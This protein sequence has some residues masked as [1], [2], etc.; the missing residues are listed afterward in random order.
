MDGTDIHKQRDSMTMP[1]SP[2]LEP[3]ARQPTS[4]EP[5]DQLSAG[6]LR[7]PPLLRIAS[8]IAGML[9]LSCAAPVTAQ[10]AAGKQTGNS[11]GK[12]R[13]ASPPVPV[14]GSIHVASPLVVVS[15]TAADP[16][17]DFVYDLNQNEVQVLDNGVP[18]EIRHFGMA[19]QPTAAVIVVEADGRTARYMNTIHPLGPLF[20]DLLLGS[21]GQAAVLTYGDQVKLLESFSSD[22]SKLEKSLEQI[23]G[24]G[25]KA[26]L[27]DALA[28]AVRMLSHEDRADRR[29]VIVFSDGTDRGS[30]TKGAQVIRAACDANVQIYGVRFQPA[31][32]AFE[33]GADELS[34]VIGQTVPPPGGPVS[35]RSDKPTYD[36]VPFAVLAMK[37]MRAQLRKNKLGTYSDFTGGK[38]YTPFKTH[39]FQDMLQQI[40]LDVNSEYVLTY[41]PST[42]K[43][44]GFHHIQLEVSRPRLRVHARPGYF[45]G[46][47][48]S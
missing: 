2:R 39:S 47:P 12:S 32:E 35:V 33:N 5:A 22:P 36:F 23:R 41:V 21:K 26:R 15:F 37:V 14:Q 9:V 48:A 40:A 10:Q 44:Q 46:I 17:G 34:K 13:T 24:T 3:P 19:S 11:S 7:R 28:Q 27:N 45:Y 20:S 4:R 6:L 16:S 30:A 43:Q 1:P 18:Q 29:I 25:K 38:V 42:L 31:K 8:L